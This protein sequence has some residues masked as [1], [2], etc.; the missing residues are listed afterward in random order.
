MSNLQAS[1]VS[2]LQTEQDPF[3]H[4]MA[5]L[6][7]MQ[8][9]LEAT[10]QR[11]CNEKILDLLL[12]DLQS[13]AR[14]VRQMPL[15]PGS[16][17]KAVQGKL[18]KH[19]RNASVELLLALD[20]VVAYGRTYRFYQHLA[21]C[22]EH[23]A[24]ALLV[25]KEDTLAGSSS[26]HE[27][28]DAP[29]LPSGD[30]HTDIQ[31]CCSA[32]LVAR[33]ALAYEQQ[34]LANQYGVSSD[35]YRALLAALIA[36]NTP[37]KSLCDLLAETRYRLNDPFAPCDQLQIHLY[38]IDEQNRRL[39]A[40]IRTLQTLSTNRQIKRICL[41]ISLTLDAL[42]QCSTEVPLAVKALLNHLPSVR[43]SVRRLCLVPSY[44]D[45]GRQEDHDV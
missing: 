33:T 12:G 34:K 15:A 16:W 31:R 21:I 40:L 30:L 5:V 11:Q 29:Q 41:E 13:T 32:I 35:C 2:Y 42:L 19:I 39:V 10:R 37:V 18:L 4:V 7:D 9:Q 1:L 24:E 23:L 44:G 27:C 3:Q 25:C 17:T 43:K 8:Q 26:L 36:L 20:Q 22:Q 28:A 38:Y 45:P 14:E 6:L